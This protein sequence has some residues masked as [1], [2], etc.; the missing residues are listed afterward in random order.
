MPSWELFLDAL[1]GDYQDIQGGTTAEG[2]HAGVMAGTVLGVIHT[3]AGLDL[4]GD[5]VKIT[6]DLPEHWNRI[7]FNFT[8]KGVNY[9]C[10]VS[11]ER[12]ILLPDSDVQVEINGERKDLLIGEIIEIECPFD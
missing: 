4:H 10:E 8:F 1:T 5:I 12:I 6:P 9:R 3:F 11:K 7:S 2:I